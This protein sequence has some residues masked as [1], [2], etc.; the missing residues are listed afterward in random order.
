MDEHIGNLINLTEAY[1]AFT[2]QLK[3]SQE[4]KKLFEA[5]IKN[6]LNNI[7]NAQ[8]SVPS[9]TTDDEIPF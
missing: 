8:A 3:T 6:E 5:A 7:I 1:K 9:E 4:I 2:T